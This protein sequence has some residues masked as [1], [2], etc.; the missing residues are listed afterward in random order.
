MDAERSKRV[1][2]QLQ[3]A[4]QVPAN[5]QDEFLRLP[6]AGDRV[7]FERRQREALLIIRTSAPSANSAS[8]RAR[9]SS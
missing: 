2:D 4:L 9:P 7:A 8:T 1:E 5:Q 3:S 6:C